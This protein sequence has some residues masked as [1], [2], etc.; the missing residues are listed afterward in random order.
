MAKIEIEEQEEV[1]EFLDRLLKGFPKPPVAAMAGQFTAPEV[2]AMSQQI[3][4]PSEDLS[5]KANVAIEILRD[6][7]SLIG[8]FP[9]MPGAKPGAIPGIKPGEPANIQSIMRNLTGIIGPRGVSGKAFLSLAKNITGVTGKL[10]AFVGVIG[11]AGAAL[12]FVTGHA[13]SLVQSLKDI[14]PSVAAISVQQDVSQLMRDLRRGEEFAPEMQDM[15]LTL[16]ELKDT[17]AGIEIIFKRG[18]FRVATPIVKAIT[19]LM[20]VINEGQITIAEALNELPIIEGHL[21]DGIRILKQNREK[22][23][24]NTT[25][26]H[27]LDA[28]TKPDFEGRRIYLSR[29]NRKAVGEGRLPTRGPFVEGE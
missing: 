15:L 28:Y 23:D 12:K 25:A 27:L 3:S 11:A 20:D 24:L 26:R 1:Q 22:E 10:L 7:R 29:Q 21:T 13:N 6:I 19:T 18:A 2:S 8:K 4:A 16:E 9:A 5:F 14:S 17:V